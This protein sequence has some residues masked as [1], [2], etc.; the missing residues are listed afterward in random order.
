MQML[1]IILCENNICEKNSAALPKLHC[2]PFYELS[3]CNVLLGRFT[4]IEDI[5][6]HFSRFT[7][8]LIH[9]MKG[10]DPLTKTGEG[11]YEL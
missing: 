11:H 7:I 2:R 10:K 1:N 9:H 5:A 6:C 4:K 8:G 3:L